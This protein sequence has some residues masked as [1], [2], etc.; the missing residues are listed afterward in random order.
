[1]SPGRRTLRLL[2]PAKLNLGLRVLGRRPD[3]YHLIESLFAPIDLADEVVLTISPSRASSPGPPAGGAA[4][5]VSFALLGEGGPGDVPADGANLAAEAARR[6]LTHAD[7]DWGV[8]VALHKRIPAGAGMGGGSSDA[9]AVLRGLAEASGVPARSLADLA[10]ALGADVPYFLDPRPAVV[11]GIGEQISPVQGLPAIELLLV[12]PGISLATADVFRAF[13]QRESAL[14]QARAGSTMRALSG[15]L[16]DS[17]ALSGG[18][19]E[20]L[21]ND[22]EPAALRLCPQIAAL[23][24]RLRGLGAKATGMSGSGATVFGL[25][26]NAAAAQEALEKA[27]FPLPIWA[28]VA[29]SIGTQ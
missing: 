24:V 11:T 27:E 17:D 22:L 16:G 23:Q 15:L 29:K 4:A 19:E 8:E 10:L 2:A 28:Q 6:F 14:T 1:M 20:L 3:G 7:L 12:N 5:R 9:G 25:F 13:D 26:P 21:V 18:L